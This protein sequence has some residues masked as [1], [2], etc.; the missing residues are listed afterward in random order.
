MKDGIM[1]GGAGGSFGG[2]AG[3]TG[4]HLGQGGGGSSPH[5]AQV[6]GTHY[7]VE[8][9][10]HWDICARL[11]IPYLEGCASAY[12]VRW[13]KKGGRADVEKALSFVSRAHLAN[14]EKAYP[15]QRYSY[16]RHHQGQNWKDAVAMAK[17]CGLPDDEAQTVAQTM[18]GHLF[19]AEGGIH[20]I[21]KKI[22]TASPGTPEDGGHHARQGDPGDETDAAKADLLR[23]IVAEGITSKNLEFLLSLCL[24]GPDKKETGEDVADAISGGLGGTP[25]EKLSGLF[26]MGQ[27]YMDHGEEDGPY[28]ED[29]IEIVTVRGTIVRLP[30]GTRVM[31]SESTVG[32]VS[33]TT[34][35]VGEDD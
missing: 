19:S 2:S 3:G 21:L 16:E 7:Q 8:G 28:E 9:E 31:V 32:E 29:Q 22:D 25:I 30:A 1:V 10:Q 11:N 6:G 26:G 15:G 33:S 4:A 24:D 17:R 13:R 5:V 12:L 14:T 35:S 23:S 27:S 34:I 18:M 20:A